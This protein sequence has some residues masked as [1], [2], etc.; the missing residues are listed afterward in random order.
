MK[1]MIVEDDF[2][3]RKLMEKLLDGYGSCDVVVDGEEAVEAFTMAWEEAE[4]YDLIFMDIMLPK[5]DGQEALKRIRAKEGEMGIQD[6]NGVKVI[7][8]SALNDPRNVVEAYNKGAASSYL[9]KPIDSEKLRE[10]IEK[11][12]S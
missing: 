5:M 2:A 12:Y 4:P 1:I 6:K 9:V 11:L 3:S 10:E 7:M 8:T